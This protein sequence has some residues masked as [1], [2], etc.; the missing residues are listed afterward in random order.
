MELNRISWMFITWQ[1]LL[2]AS[3]RFSYVYPLSDSLWLTIHTKLSSK[4]NIVLVAMW[5]LILDT[6]WDKDF[7]TTL[8]GPCP[9]LTLMYHLLH[10]PK[11][12]HIC[13]HCRSR[14]C[15]IYL[16]W[17]P[18]LAPWLLQLFKMHCFAYWPTIP[19]KGY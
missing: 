19:P 9:L 5:Q 15:Q 2:D 10:L 13:F 4:Q 17:G 3:N 6:Y 7:L 14:R 12:L 1:L 8:Y 11:Y 18:S 16:I